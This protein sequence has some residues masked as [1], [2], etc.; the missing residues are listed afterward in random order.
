MGLTF[1]MGLLRKLKV[2]SLRGLE[3][4]VLAVGGD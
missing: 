1:E 3:R 4:D 2:L